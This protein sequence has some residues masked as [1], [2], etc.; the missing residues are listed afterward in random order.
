MKFQTYGTPGSPCILLIHGMFDDGSMFSPLIPCLEDRYFLVIPTLDG[1]D[2]DSPAEYPGADEELRRVEAY[3]AGENIGNL[4]AAAGSSLGA[5]LVWRLSQRGAIPIRRLVL[6]SAPF[7]WETSLAEENTAGFWEVVRQVRDLPPD[8]L[9]VFEKNYGD[10]GP[11]MRRSCQHVTYE[12]I[13]RSCADCFGVKLPERVG[14]LSGGAVVLCYGDQDPN[15]Q[16]HGKKLAGRPDLT[17]DVRTGF[18]HCGF[19]MERP[20]EFAAL[21]RGV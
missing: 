15:Y 19:L 2:A 8:T 6:D 16:E 3:L 1:Y 9:S 10:M 12:T 20:E 7:G 18:G 17:L 5:M 13:R 11:V 14:V 21:L 4:A